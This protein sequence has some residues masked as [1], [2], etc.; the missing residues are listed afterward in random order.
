MKYDYPISWTSEEFPLMTTYA[1]YEAGM[2][3]FWNLGRGGLCGG[4]K[5]RRTWFDSMRFHIDRATD[6]HR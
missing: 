4:L 3:S 6:Y 1:E 5:I 2:S